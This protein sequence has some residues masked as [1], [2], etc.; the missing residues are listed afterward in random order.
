MASSGKKARRQASKIKRRLERKMA[1]AARYAA[2]AGQ[3]RKGKKQKRKDPNRY[4]KIGEK[5]RNTASNYR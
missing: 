2:S 5:M 1:K 3:S 4:G